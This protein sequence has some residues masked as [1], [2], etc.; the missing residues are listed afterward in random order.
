[1]V[2]DGDAN[3]I[4]QLPAGYTS[5]KGQYFAASLPN[6]SA[7]GEIIVSFNGSVSRNNAVFPSSEAISLE[8]ISFRVP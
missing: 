6:N 1:M 4:F 2:E 7:A 8:G 3:P 5:G